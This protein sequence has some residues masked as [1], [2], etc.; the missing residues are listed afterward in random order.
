MP[1]SASFFKQMSVENTFFASLCSTFGRSSALRN[2]SANEGRTRGKASNLFAM[3]KPSSSRH[4]TSSN[5]WQKIDSDNINS[6]AKMANPAWPSPRDILKV[7]SEQPEAER[8]GV[9][10]GH[11]ADVEEESCATRTDG[12][13]KSITVNITSRENHT[14]Q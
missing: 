13:M 2:S 12:I 9:K 11:A 6:R 5:S 8:F 1:A 3:K 14:R 10:D 4:P 7:H